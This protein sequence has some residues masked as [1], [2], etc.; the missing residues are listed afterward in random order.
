M[1]LLALLQEVGTARGNLPTMAE[2]VTSGAPRYAALLALLGDLLWVV[3]YII[4]IV[5][6]LRQRTYAIPMVAIGL[7]VNWEIVHTAIHPPPVFVNLVANLVWLA[8][9]LLIVLQLIRYGRERQT[10]EVLKR[11]FAP[12]VVGMLALALV[13]HATFYTHVT[14]NA[15]FPDT[16]GVVSAFLINLVMSVLF[17]GMYFSRPDGHGISKAIAWLKMIGTGAISVANVIAFKTMAVQRYEVQIRKQGTTEWIDPGT[18][19]SQSVSPGFLYFL[20]VAILIF[21]V[22]YLVLL[23]RGRAGGRADGRA[24]A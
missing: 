17:I 18:I 2:L 5:I 9:D 14:E 19:G 3:V 7:N 20:F 13:G 21:D 16:D 24:V 6:G 10:N 4:A 22:A 12:I 23:Y 15:I 8:F 1:L 11:Y